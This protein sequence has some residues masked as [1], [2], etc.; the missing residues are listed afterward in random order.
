MQKK[1]KERGYSGHV[2]NRKFKFSSL[3]KFEIILSLIITRISLDK[4]FHSSN[5][6]F[7]IICNRPPNSNGTH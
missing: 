7:L 2:T 5:R 1:E 6:I 4:F 3:K